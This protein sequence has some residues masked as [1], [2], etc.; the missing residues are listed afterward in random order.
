MNCLYSSSH[1]VNLIDSQTMSTAHCTVL[2]VRDSS[3]PLS[4]AIIFS[5]FALSLPLLWGKFNL[6]SKETKN[7]FI[8][9]LVTIK[10]FVGKVAPTGITFRDLRSLREKPPITTISHKWI[11]TRHF[12]IPHFCSY[13]IKHSNTLIIL[14]LSV[15]RSMYYEK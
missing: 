7:H 4:L 8:T 6:E 12:D 10:S 11:F 3:S 1:S 2:C 13:L 9:H 14:L 5:S 15:V